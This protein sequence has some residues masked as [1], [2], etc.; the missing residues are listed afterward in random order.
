M[1][2]THHSFMCMLAVI[3]TLSVTQLSSPAYAD[4]PDYA[5]ETG[6]DH[7]RAYNHKRELGMHPETLTG[8][9]RAEGLMLSLS[10]D[11]LAILTQDPYPMHKRSSLKELKG[12]WW[13]SARHLCLSFE[14]TPIC[15]LIDLDAVSRDRALRVNVGGA[16]IKLL[17]VR[18][19]DPH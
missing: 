13:F 12:L 1:T 17:N 3:S 11:G 6:R 15:Y 10:K 19:K 9:W 4:Q 2:R 14:L 7:E 8:R 18:R 16:S 5:D